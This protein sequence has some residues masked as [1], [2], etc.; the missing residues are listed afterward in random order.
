MN[1]WMKKHG[2]VTIGLVI[3]IIGLIFMYRQHLAQ[4]KYFNEHVKQELM[5]EGDNK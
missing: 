3:C 2:Q 5:T 1:K 4:V